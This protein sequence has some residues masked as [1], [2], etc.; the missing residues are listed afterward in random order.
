MT[1]R[2]SRHRQAWRS[3]LALAVTCA[4]APPA[5]A[6][7]PF[8]HVA[9]EAVAAISAT[10]TDFTDPMIVLDATG[11]VHLG[12]GFDA[13]VRP[14]ARRLPGGDWAS[15]MYQLQVRYQATRGVPLRVDAGILSSPIGLG[16]LELRPDRNPT[17]SA[18]Y[19]YYAPLP[20][21][22][23][24]GDRVQLISGGYPLGIVAAAS[25]TT[26]DVRAGVTDGSPVVSRDALAGDRPPAA[27]Q[28]VLGGGITPMPG[29]RVGAGYA[30]GAYRSR[31][32]ALSAPGGDQL[33]TVF[34]LEGE[35]AVGYTRVAGEWIIDR[36][37]T[38]GPLAIARGFTVVA[39]H[40]LT[41]RWFAAGRLVRS[42]SP[43]WR[44]GILTRRQAGAAET[45]VGY[46]LTR[47]LTLR[48]AWQT[49]R[50][51]TRTN[52]QHAAAVS[53]VWS[54]RHW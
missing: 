7:Q 50:P 8:G 49:S 51:Y 40:T 48:A 41:P 33:A 44:A 27:A 25:G 13:V 26:W 54:H 11:T 12:S 37:H 28:L 16:T 2:P 32:A 10:S 35:Y 38:T 34:N 30:R 9:M 4:L 36:I 52:W 15:Q 20:P 22:D 5:S 19:Y 45:T 3:G 1:R 42:S 17:I 23:A 47:D 21:L 46:L 53:M 31:S 6:Q 14:Y 43:A 24:S 29:L 39:T 18:P